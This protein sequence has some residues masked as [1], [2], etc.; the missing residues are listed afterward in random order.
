MTLKLASIYQVVQMP[1]VWYDGA[2][3]ALL[4]VA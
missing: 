4:M 2:I 1:N 3:V